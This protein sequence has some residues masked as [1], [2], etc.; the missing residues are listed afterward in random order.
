[1]NRV[2]KTFWTLATMLAGLW[3]L[4]TVAQN[5]VPVSTRYKAL[6]CPAA[7]LESTWSILDRNGANAQVTPYLSSL[8]R[9]EAGTGVI[10]SP[11]FVIAVDKITFTLCGHDGQAGDRGENYIAL[12][13][14]RKGN[15]LLKIPPPQ[16]DAMQQQERNV[17]GHRGTEVRI[18]FHDGNAGNGFAWWGVG[19]ID[20]GQALRI[21]FK[22][23]MPKGWGQAQQKEET[24]HETI[25]G[26]VPFKRDTNVFT[27]I[28]KEGAVE[29]P[30]GF[31]ANRLF[32][33]GGTVNAFKPLET[34]GGIEVHYA[35]GSPDVFPLM[36]GFTL[37]GRYKLLSPAKIMHLHVSDDPYQHYLAIQPRKG[38]IDKIR[39]VAQ[40]DRYPIPRITAI[41]CETSA[42]SE[43]LLPL[44]ET[45]PDTEEIAWI[46]SHAIA[47]D[48]P[49]LAAIMAEIRKAHEIPAV[50]NTT[51]VRFRKHQIDKAF[52][53]EGVA[54]A[55]FNADGQLDIAVGSVYYAA[56][57]WKPVPILSE[58]KKFNR[59]GY[60]DSFL[61]FADDL[62]SDGMVDLIV[63]GFPGQQTHWFENPGKPGSPWKKHLAITQTDNESPTYTD[64]D[65]DGRRELICLN[66]GKCVLA[67]PGQD[68]TQPWELHAISNDGDPAP[69]HGLGI[70][71]IN[72]DGALDVVIADGWWQGP[73]EPTELPWRF[74]VARIFGGAQLCVHDFDGDGDNDVLGSSPHAYGI[75]WSEQTPDGWKTHD[76]GN[77]ISQTHAIHLADINCDGLMDFVTGKRFW[78]HNGRD[79]GSFLPSVLCWFEQQRRNGRT[80]WKKH[81]IDVTSG[82]GLHFKI[83]DINNDG[84]PDIVTANKKGVYYFEQLGT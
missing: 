73:H 79:P 57:D 55:D 7:S 78:A 4:A 13:D 56:P 70:G 17:K 28:P 8:G 15:V 77:A 80:V 23:G 22:D 18:E 52:R 16:S 2:N 27:L 44:P 84:R 10:T 47:A 66:N 38:T 63:V 49:D 48:T 36:C 39:L 76:I 26:T 58:T 62:N 24:R 43:R 46:Q 19:Q 11:P 74:H 33:L 1:V 21:N 50:G 82:V 83:V 20:A 35:D 51:P 3:P 69:A 6:K 68:P 40:P 25:G 14:A 12:V 71:D 32:F 31:T 34:C 60:S 42:E 81:L 54:V 45:S 61:C 29:I 75:A 41:T 67:Q 53:S 64:I 5:A 37:D 9:G 72:K 30:C 65:G 59:Y